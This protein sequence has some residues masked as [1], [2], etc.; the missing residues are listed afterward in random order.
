MVSHG[1]S[2]AH[3]EHESGILARSS[4][5]APPEVVEQVPAAREL[6]AQIIMFH[7]GADKPRFAVRGVLNH[8]RTV[9]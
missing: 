4:L 5:P 6:A 3:N 2:T 8:H 1:H 7:H 9:S